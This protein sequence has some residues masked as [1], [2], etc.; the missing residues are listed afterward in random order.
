MEEFVSFVNSEGGHRIYNAQAMRDFISS[1]F[2][3]GV[4]SGGFGVEAQSG[5]TVTIAPGYANIEGVIQYKQYDDTITLDVAEA[6][7]DRIDSIAIELSEEDREITMKY[8]KGDAAA[9]PEPKAPVRSD[10]IYQLI[11]AQILIPAGSVAITQQNITDTRE[12]AEICGYISSRFA[13]I[14]FDQMTAQFAAYFEETKAKDLAEFNA[15]FESD[16]HDIDNAT[17]NNLMDELNDSESDVSDLSNDADDVDDAADD[18]NN[19]I[20]DATTISKSNISSVYEVE[21]D[22]TPPAYPTNH[23]EFGEEFPIA[24]GVTLA[25]DTGTTLLPREFVKT[26]WA[27]PSS[28]PSES[29][30]QVSYDGYATIGMADGNNAYSMAVR[31]YLRV[32]KANGV[33]YLD[34]TGSDFSIYDSVVIINNLGNSGGNM[35]LTCYNWCPATIYRIMKI[36]G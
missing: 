20:G 30:S 12:D 22:T 19:Y 3:N 25:F 28:K 4:F 9:E 31:L 8:V 34:C 2:N 33:C 14:N 15:W 5:M 29:S 35:S 1:F 21:L 32:R 24:L 36:D 18:V 17:Y 16:F 7:L 13:E 6:T 10:G 27:I 11:I 26:I 23:V